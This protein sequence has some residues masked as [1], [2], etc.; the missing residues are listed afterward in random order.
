[1][2]I[3]IATFNLENLFTR[4]TA[5]RDGIGP[6][7]QQALDDFA[8]LN[9]IVEKTAYSAADKQ[10]LVGLS[11]NYGF[12]LLN[13]PADALIKLQKIREALFSEAGGNL[14]VKANG[15]GDWTGWFELRR[16]DVV[17]QSTN[18]AAL[19]IATVD[20]DILV[21]VEAEDRPTL[22][23]FNDQVLKAGLNKDY[24]HVML[25]DGN[26]E[27]GIDVG[28]LSRFPI[29][30]AIPH[31]DDE[32][33]AGKKIFSRDCPEYDIELPGGGSLVV[34][35]NHF[36][37]KRGGN[38]PAASARRK[39]QATRAH[40][41]AVAALARSPLVLLAGDFNDIPGGPELAPLFTGGFA[42]VLSHPNYPQDRPGTFDTGLAIGKID[43]LIMSTA[44]NAKILDTGIERRGTYRP[45][46]WVPFPSVT[47]KKNEA[48][49]HH[50]LWATFD[51]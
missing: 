8:T 42:D 32:D 7:G 28:I 38:S 43:Y 21:C 50:C 2:T 17:W 5:M 24:P 39:A 37:S 3:K 23:R 29:R 44:L 20:P 15:R 48:S 36:K 4:P 6:E 9:V 25:I 33:N 51:F 30:S 34:C 27:R 19:V 12:H 46:T 45:N 11:E 41:I 10:T 22:Q 16:D 31:F 40:E 18:N 49:D 13:A 35:P 1:M 26:D 47:S 14:H